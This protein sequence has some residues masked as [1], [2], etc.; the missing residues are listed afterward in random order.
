MHALSADGKAGLAVA[1]VGSYLGGCTFW[2]ATHLPN[3]Q[4]LAVEQWPVATN[5]M[6]RTA[7]ANGC[8]GF[9]L[10]KECL[11]GVQLVVGCIWEPHHQDQNLMLKV[12]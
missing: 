6:K 10:T 3:I 5:A 2:A 8:P 1:E 4:A 12:V 7:E 11:G 9:P